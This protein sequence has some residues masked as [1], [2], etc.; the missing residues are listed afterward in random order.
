MAVY[1]APNIVTD[2]IERSLRA[3]AGVSKHRG[4]A[5]VVPETELEVVADSERIV[6]V[7]V[8]LLSNAIKFSPAGSEVRVSVKKIDD[9]WVEIR[10]SDAGPGIP[11]EFRDSIFQ[12]FEQLTPETS[13]NNSADRVGSGLGLAICKTIIE[14]HGGTLGVDGSEHGGSS[15]YFRIRG[16]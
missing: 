10:V 8:N 16:V 11:V 5:V 13:L 2:I 1:L 4:I 14:G 3:V 7:M 6:Q 15:F 9:D 12:R